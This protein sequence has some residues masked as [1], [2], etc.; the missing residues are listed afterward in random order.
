M[1]I[2]AINPNNLFNDINIMSRNSG[3][4]KSVV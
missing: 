1:I 3:D 4:R 2:R